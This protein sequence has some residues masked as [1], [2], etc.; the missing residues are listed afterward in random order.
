LE[1]LERMLPAG[2]VTGCPKKRAVEEIDALE[3]FARGPYTGVF[4]SLSDDG[5]LSSSVLIRTAVARNRVLSLSVGGGIVADSRC[6]E[7]YAETLAKAAAF[8]HLREAVGVTRINGMQAQH[9]DPKLQ[10]L[11]PLKARD[12]A[13]F[14]TLRTYSGRLFELDAHCRRLRTSARLLGMRLPMPL[15]SI[16]ETIRTA[17]FCCGPAPLRIKVV[18]TARD[19][20]LRVA[21]LAE[22]PEIYRGAHA[23]FVRAERHTPRAKALPYDVS[24]RAHARATRDGCEE[25]LLLAPDGRV[26]EGAYSNLFWVKDG[27]LHPEPRGLIILSFLVG[28]LATACAYPIEKFI[29]ASESGGD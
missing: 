8:L 19:V 1:A 12:N 26:P 5:Q 10:L 25:A 4:L 13:V 21:P 3:P 11:Q 14:E 17:A 24:A 22:R 15:E 29:M 16:A 9:D 18:A 2:S 7:E 6:E 20:I 28:M 27:V 23:M